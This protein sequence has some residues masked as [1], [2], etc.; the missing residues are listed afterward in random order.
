MAAP[1][2]SS[3]PATPPP[4]GQRRVGM[5]VLAAAVIGALVVAGA[6]GYLIGH[7]KG[8]DSGKEDGIAQGRREGI[9]A[10]AARYRPGQPEYVLIYDAGQRA[11]K[12]TGERAGQRTGEQEGEKT[13]EKEGEQAG[14]KTGE[15]E[16]RQIGFQQGEKKGEAAGEATGESEGIASGSSAVLNGFDTWAAGGLYVVTMQR[17]QDVPYVVSTRHLME[18]ALNYRLCQ[19]NPQ[20]LCEAPEAE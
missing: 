3:V 18:P 6:G 13:G 17:G 11:G 14:Q 9:I 15:K 1:E 4:G 10:T 7:G 19:S 5:G 2:Q 12:K 8:E 16:G 20:K